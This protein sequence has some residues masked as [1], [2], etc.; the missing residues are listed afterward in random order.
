[1]I[2]RAAPRSDAPYAFGEH[3]A[4]ATS[5]GVPETQI[6][7]LRNGD[8]LEGLFDELERT[9]LAF[10]DEVLD[11]SHF[12]DATFARVREHFSPREAVELLPPLAAF[13]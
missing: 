4:I 11:R 10:A 6:S 1:V 13:E 3:A 7:S 9:E 12:S 2:L 8:V 5:V